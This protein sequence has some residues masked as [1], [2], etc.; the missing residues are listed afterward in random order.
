VGIEKRKFAATVSFPGRSIS[1]IHNREH[2]TCRFGEVGRGNPAPTR[3]W[4][5]A[6]HGSSS[7]QLS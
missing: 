6:V 4:P 5:S 1:P 3:P 2:P 7:Y